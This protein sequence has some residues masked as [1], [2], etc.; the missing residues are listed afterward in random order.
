MEKKGNFFNQIATISDLLEKINIE[1]ESRTVIL[2]L[3]EEEFD[4]MYNMV[5]EKTKQNIKSVK[6]KFSITIG[7][8]SVI[9]SKNNV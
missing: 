5:T 1:S 3:K 4:R 8:V 9:F 7:E 6:N 2:E